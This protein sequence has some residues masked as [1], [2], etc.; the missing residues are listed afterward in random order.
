MPVLMRDREGPDFL[1]RAY[2]QSSPS[3]Q[4]RLAVEV[5]YLFAPVVKLLNKQKRPAF[6]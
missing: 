4:K 5:S 2:L 3:E 6:E 1:K